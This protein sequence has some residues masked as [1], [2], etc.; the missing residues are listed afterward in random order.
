MKNM[1]KGYRQELIVSDLLEYGESAELRY[2]MKSQSRYSSYCESFR[3]LF[4]R[5]FAAGYSV[6]WQPGKLG[7][8][9]TA[10][11]ILN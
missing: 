7:G 9:W 3:N 5:L 1:A 11:I 4:D 2:Y 8:D 6:Q 10:K